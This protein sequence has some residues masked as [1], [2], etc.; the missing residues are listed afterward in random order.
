MV[1]VRWGGLW[2]TDIDFLERLLVPVPVAA[3]APLRKPSH[4]GPL[5]VVM[6]AKIRQARI[7]PNRQRCIWWAMGDRKLFGVAATILDEFQLHHP[8]PSATSIEHSGPLEVA[9]WPDAR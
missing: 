3:L 8:M 6:L 2:V 7:Q 9:Y 5:E 4:D 1:W